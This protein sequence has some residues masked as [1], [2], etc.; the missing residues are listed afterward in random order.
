MAP[1]T[2]TTERHTAPTQP[3][4]WWLRNMIGDYTHNIGSKRPAVIER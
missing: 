4:E 2:A 3:D 1:T